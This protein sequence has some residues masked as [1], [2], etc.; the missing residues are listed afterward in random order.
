MKKEYLNNNGIKLLKFDSRKSDKKVPCVIW[1]HGG[2]YVR[3]FPETIYFS[4]IF[5]TL[6]KHE[7]IIIS[8]KYRLAS[9][10]PYP[11]GLEDC[12]STLEYVIENA[13]KL[14]IDKNKIIVGGESAGGGLALATTIYALKKNNNSIKYIFPLYPMIDCYDTISS[15]D[16]HGY[17]WNTRKN[18]K[19]W[20]KY[21]K[22][23]DN[24][25][26]IPD[27]ASPSRLKDY[28]KL[29]PFYTFVGDGEPFYYEIGK[30]VDNAKKVGVDAKIDVY[31]TKIH[32]FDMVT[33]G[34]KNRKLARKKFLKEFDEAIN[35]LN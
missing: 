12:Y 11:A 1:F 7:L 35:N 19:A 28:T 10:Y 22:N 30:F 3:G 16:N 14:G 26:S 31:H 17:I 23:I 21:L 6:K 27:T 5:P 9:K 8:P 29:P 34:S 33:F 18:H 15:I 4:S 13:S 20:K 25:K 32:A 24:T 2:G